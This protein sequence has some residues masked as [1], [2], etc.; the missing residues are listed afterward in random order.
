M[1]NTRYFFERCPNGH[2]LYWEEGLLVSMTL[3]LEM[4]E[5]LSVRLPFV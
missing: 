3:L 2:M 1:K 4:R 5:T